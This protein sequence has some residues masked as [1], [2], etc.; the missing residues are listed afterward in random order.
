VPTASWGGYGTAAG[1]FRDP[2]GVS[3]AGDEVYVADSFNH[4]VQ[5]F[6]TDGTFLR[7]WRAPEP[8]RSTFRP[9]GIDVDAGIVYVTDSDD[10]VV[11][12][13][14]P[15]GTSL[16][17]F[18]TGVPGGFDAANGVDARGGDVYVADGS[19]DRIVRLHPDG[20]FVSTFGVTGSGPGELLFPNDVAVAPGGDVYVADSENHRIQ[21]FTADGTLVSSFGSLGQGS[22]GFNLPY[23]V[24]VDEVGDVYVGDTLNQ[25]VKKY[26]ADGTFLARWDGRAI[27]PWFGPTGLDVATDGQVYVTTAAHRVVRFTATTQ[28]DLRIKAGLTGAFVGDDVYNTT[29]ADQTRHLTVR[30]GATATFVVWVQDDARVADVL[31]LRGTTTS[32][33]FRVHYSVDGA[34]RTTAI[35]AG[36]YLTPTL[37]PGATHAVRIDVTATANARAGAALD[38]TLTATSTTDTARKDRVRFVTTVR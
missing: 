36:T 21:R 9:T 13:F 16:G 6:D 1:Q 37:D 26:T 31:R 8:Y 30:P 24:A 17:T 38:A 3:V 14:L 33:T 28:P 15:D 22:Y 27:G 4:R 2:S 10:D 11:L 32:G 25:K 20:T 5:V 29:G 19:H 35:G 12:R 18:G 23:R 7:S 34:R